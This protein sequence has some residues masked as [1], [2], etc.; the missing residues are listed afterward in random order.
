MGISAHLQQSRKMKRIAHISHNDN[1]R[2]PRM[3]INP[4][5]REVA[6]ARPALFMGGGGGGGGG[7]QEIPAKSKQTGGGPA[8]VHHLRDFER[9]AP[10]YL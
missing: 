3:G 6:P 5:R 1:P 9:D 7:T 4:I 8:F 2:I 10:F